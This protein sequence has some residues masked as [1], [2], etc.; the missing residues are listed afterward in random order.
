MP[1]VI[2]NEGAPLLLSYTLGIQE[3]GSGWTVQLYQNDYTP[4]P[5]TTTSSF[6][7]CDFPGSDGISMDPGD[8][9][10][11]TIISNRASATFDPSSP[12][13]WT[14]GGSSAQT[15][16]G[17]FVIDPSSNVTVFAERFGTPRTLNAGDALLLTV[18]FTGGTQT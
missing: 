16:Y 9:N 14:N 8:W 3:F 17:Y 11:P 18:I 12:L 15:A 5:S 10:D 7:P 4:I 2:P 13:L 6:T 1:I